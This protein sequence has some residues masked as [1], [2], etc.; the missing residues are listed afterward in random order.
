MQIAIASNN[1]NHVDLL[2]GIVETHPDCTLAW[3]AQNADD[4]IDK[5]SV[6]HPDLLFM[7]LKL[8]P[9]GGVLTTGL[10]MRT[11][12]C[13]ILLVVSSV[14]QNSS[15][16]FEAMGYGALDVVAL[17]SGKTEEVLVVLLKKIETIFRLLGK[18]KGYFNK[19]K[20]TEESEETGG[21][22]RS[23]PQLLIFG[24]STGG[25]SAIASI[26]A[27]FSHMDDIAIVIIQHVDE[28]FSEPLA[29]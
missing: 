16:I 22:K 24:A 12:P 15:E 2:R 3:V 8:P 5:C 27:K 23:L 29:K 26:L 17:P 6:V 10:I 28:K 1:K 21:I 4:A 25:P 14:A 19:G 13:A 11:T 20:L 7:D 9:K 18:T